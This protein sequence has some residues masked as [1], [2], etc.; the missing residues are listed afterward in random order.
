MQ[1][2]EFDKLIE[3]GPANWAQ[4]E[5]LSNLKKLT[6]EQA[7]EEIKKNETPIPDNIRNDI[8]R[9]ISEQRQKGI[10]ERTIRRMVQRKWNIKVI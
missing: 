9:F 2:K 8:N 5:N 4:M 3:G 7:K 10:R 6:K 1:S